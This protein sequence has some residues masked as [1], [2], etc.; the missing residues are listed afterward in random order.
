MIDITESPSLISFAGNPVIFEACSSDYLV[1]LGTRALFEM[2]VSGIDTNIGHSFT[3]KFAGKTLVF[4]TAGITEFDGLLFEVAYYTQTFNDFANNIYQCFLENYDI[5]KFYD[6]TLGPV[7]TGDRRITLAAKEPGDEYSVTLTNVGVYGVSQGTITPGI[8]DVYRDF[9][10]ILCLIR[11]SYGSTIGEDIKPSDFMGAARFDISDYLQAKFSAWEMNRFEFPELTGNVRMHGWDYLLKYKVSFTESIAGHVKGLLTTRWNYALAGGLSRELLASLNENY[12]D[13]FSIEANKMRFLTWLPLTKYSRSGVTEK[14]FFLFQDNPT[15][16]QYRL[17]VIVNFTDGS[18][19]LINATPMAAFPPFSVAEFKVGF[20]HLNLVN[21]WYG[22][23]VKSW[24]VVL[25]DSND[26][27][28]S[29]RRIFINDTRVF[30]NEKVFFYRNSFSAY[31]TFRFLGKSE[32]NLEYERAAGNTIREEKDTFFNAPARQF[33]SKETESCK[34]N[35]G[36]ISL[37]E[38]Q[39]LRELLLSTEAYEQIGKELFRIL[40]KSAK[41]TPFLKDGE[42]LYNLEIEYERAYQNSF[43]S[44]HTPESSANPII[45]PEALTWDNIEVSFDDMEITFDQ[46]TF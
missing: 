5:Q 20:D 8:D 7:G 31:D 6:V 28:L 15:G 19:K 35:S 41:V 46:V 3:L 43:F 24:E 30:D 14:L 25:M 27:Y 38:K 13:Y 16:I 22:R 2:V 12:Q 37:T 32:T 34:A 40:V 11:D 36:W 44:L 21:A 17:V 39:C 9:F 33:G 29:E 45:P 1:S 42:Y 26:D 10:G 4:K 18:H 23:T